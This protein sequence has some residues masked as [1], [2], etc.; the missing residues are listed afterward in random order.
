MTT[1]SKLLF[2]LVY[3]PFDT[4]RPPVN[5]SSPDLLTART[6]FQTRTGQPFDPHQDARCSCSPGLLWL[7]P[8]RSCPAF[9]GRVSRVCI[10]FWGQCGVDVSVI[11]SFSS[12]SQHFLLVLG[13]QEFTVLARSRCQRLTS[14]FARF[15][16]CS[17]PLR[18][19]LSALST[20]TTCDG[21]D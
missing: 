12:T 2:P 10:V 17:H 1:R 11:T 13:L 18:S 15:A 8:N 19:L 16:S 14:A 6:H 4:L 21:I 9:Q 7:P 20:F 3:Q 5:R